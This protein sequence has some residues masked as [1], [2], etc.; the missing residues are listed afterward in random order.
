MRA[1]RLLG[2]FRHLMAS[3]SETI[4]TT[5]NLYA[6]GSG[7][8]NHHPRN[9]WCIPLGLN[10]VL[11]ICKFHFLQSFWG[12]KVGGAVECKHDNIHVPQRTVE[13]NG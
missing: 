5:T 13:R 1:F 7:E 6:Y 11:K 3:P 12:R 4:P 10:P 9:K 2:N 8:G